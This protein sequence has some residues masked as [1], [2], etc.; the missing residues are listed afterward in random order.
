MTE[1]HPN[2]NFKRK[3]CNG[4]VYKRR[5]SSKLMDTIVAENPYVSFDFMKHS[6]EGMYVLLMHRKTNSSTHHLSRKLKSKKSK[7]ITSTK[8]VIAYLTTVR[9][10]CILVF[11]RLQSIV[12]L[13]NVY[14][15]SEE[16]DKMKKSNNKQISIRNMRSQRHDG[17]L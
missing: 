17:N 15:K 7:S 4:H 5:T 10:L 9:H 12:G 8:F 11:D 1:S 13:C 14:L 3:K 2:M 16:C 6:P